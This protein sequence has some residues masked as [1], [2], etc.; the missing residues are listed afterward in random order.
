MGKA[1]ESSR[2]V[3]LTCGENMTE[4]ILYWSTA[5]L[6]GLAFLLFV[7]SAGMLNAN[8][9]LQQNINQRQTVINT[10]TNVLPL[11]QQLSNALYDASVKNKDKA[12]RTLLVSQGF[13]LPDASKKE[14]DVKAEK[15]E[16]KEEVE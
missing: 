10:A 7:T 3:S 13:T 9:K 6:A 4:K 8:L 16:K 12:I 1:Y 2:R 11:N 14:P 5:F 15:K